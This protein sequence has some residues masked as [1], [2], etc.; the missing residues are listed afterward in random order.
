MAAER[1]A[2]AMYKNVQELVLAA[3]VSDIEALHRKERPCHV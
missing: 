3:A 2:A 1:V